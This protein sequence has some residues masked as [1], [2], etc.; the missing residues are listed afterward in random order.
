MPPLALFGPLSK[1]Q[2]MEA[3]DRLKVLVAQAEEDV[4]KVGGGN[5]AA[6]TRLRKTMQEI[7]SAAQEVRVKV[8][9]QRSPP[10]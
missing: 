3:F 1:E 6:G 4:I 7:K 5:K 8:L 9:E 2:V 10:A